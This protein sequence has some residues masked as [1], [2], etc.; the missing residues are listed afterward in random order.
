MKVDRRFRNGFLMTNSYTLGR[1]ENYYGGDS[2]GNISTPADIERS[3]G[4]PLN[5][6]A[7]IFV[8]SYVYGLPFKKEG[9]LGWLVNGWQLSRLFTRSPAARSTSRRA[10][11]CCARPATRSGRT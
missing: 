4:C 2:N 8:S 10:A 7:H 6:R 1:G 5:D 11:R 3:W 9:I